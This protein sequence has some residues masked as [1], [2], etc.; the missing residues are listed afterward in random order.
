MMVKPFLTILK[1]FTVVVIHCKRSIYE[2]CLFFVCLFFCFFGREKSFYVTTLG[3]CNSSFKLME[4]IQ[5]EKK[6]M[7]VSTLLFHTMWTNSKVHY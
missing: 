2:V 4:S 7:Q 1:D 5:S 6:C 3:I